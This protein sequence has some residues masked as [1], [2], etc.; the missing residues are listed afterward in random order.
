[1]NTELIPKTMLSYCLQGKLMIEVIIQQW[2]CNKTNAYM[3]DD[4]N[5]KL[6]LVLLRAGM[7]PNS[8]KNTRMLVVL[9][10]VWI[11]VAELMYT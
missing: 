11:Q 6:Q 8:M 9:T 1:M 4:D 3:E 10:F 5:L 2:D 7:Y